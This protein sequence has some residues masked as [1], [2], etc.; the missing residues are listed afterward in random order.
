MKGE[1]G[2]HRPVCRIGNP[3]LMSQPM[4]EAIINFHAVM[5]GEDGM[6]FGAD[7][8]AKDRSEAYEKLAENYPE[9]RVDQL[10]SPEDTAIRQEKIY[11]EA[12]LGDSEFHDLYFDDCDD[13]EEYWE[14]KN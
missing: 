6:E 1:T 9:S 11:A 4:E 10:E 13:C 2:R 5:I 3:A 7:V 12:L 8:E 14:S